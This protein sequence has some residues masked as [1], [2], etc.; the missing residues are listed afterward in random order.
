M[1]ENLVMAFSCDTRSLFRIANAKLNSINL[2]QYP[3]M[4]NFEND[5]EAGEIDPE[6]GHVFGAD[7]LTTLKR[8][9]SGLRA[10]HEIGFDLQFL[11]MTMKSKDGEER[12]SRMIQ[13]YERSKKLC[14]QL[15][16]HVD[17]AI[18]EFRSRASWTLHID[19]QDLED[20][21][22]EIHNAT[23]R[24][25]IFSTGKVVDFS[26]DT[27]LIREMIIPPR[28]KFPVNVGHLSF[29]RTDSLKSVDEV[30][31]LM[32]KIREPAEEDG[33]YNISR[34][35]FTKAR[36]ALGLLTNLPRE[37]SA[38]FIPVKNVVGHKRSHDA[39]EFKVH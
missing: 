9:A 6:F 32:C 15:L 2:K 19:I 11:E 5:V 13:E 33:P 16:I 7:F 10:E 34:K 21:A 25:H 17:S 14:N 23:G 31:K 8:I 29:L 39:V 27:I 35:E 24:F 18:Q 1:S 28:V 37:G 26:S 12:I 20:V 36:I 22:K 38:R 3:Y 30:L 4:S